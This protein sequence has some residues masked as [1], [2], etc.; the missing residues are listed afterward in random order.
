MANFHSPDAEIPPADRVSHPYHP[1]V[2]NRAPD[3]ERHSRILTPEQARRVWLAIENW[4]PDCGESEQ[5]DSP[6]EP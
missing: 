6:P 4:R 3:A 2:P 5:S 1:L